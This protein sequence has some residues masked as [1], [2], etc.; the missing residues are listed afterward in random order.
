MARVALLRQLVWVACLG[1]VPV[2]GIA[3]AL[4]KEA[5]EKPSP[6]GDCCAASAGI[7]VA[8]RYGNVGRGQM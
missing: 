3:A 6:I 4:L 7:W 2:S 5:V 1:S 8:I